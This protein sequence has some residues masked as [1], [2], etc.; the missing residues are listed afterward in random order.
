MTIIIG[1]QTIDFALLIEKQSI[2]CIKP[3][4]NK[5]NHKKIAKY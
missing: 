1:Q 4:Q 2:D 3:S 5:N